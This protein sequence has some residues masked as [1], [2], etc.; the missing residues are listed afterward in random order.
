MKEVLTE[1]IKEII[2]KKKNIVTA[3]KVTI[4]YNTYI[5][6]YCNMFENGSIWTYM[7]VFHGVKIT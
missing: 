4:Q 2:F 3:A 7:Y 6:L 1:W 5:F